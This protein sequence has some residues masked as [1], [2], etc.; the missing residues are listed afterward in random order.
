MERCEMGATSVDAGRRVAGVARG[1]GCD[2]RPIEQRFGV[3]PLGWRDAAVNSLSN[4]FD[5]G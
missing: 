4:V 2:G 5:A 3:A 1:V